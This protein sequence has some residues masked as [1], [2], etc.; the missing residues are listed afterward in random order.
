MNPE[1]SPASYARS[2]PQLKEVPGC[3]LGTHAVNGRKLKRNRLTGPTSPGRPLGE[4]G[5]PGPGPPAPPS[6]PPR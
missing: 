1:S 3:S 6:V 4:L 5:V 2:P